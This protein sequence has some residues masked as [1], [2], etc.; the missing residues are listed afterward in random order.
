MAE[1]KQD[2][3]IGYL[4]G[5]F[6]GFNKRFGEF[7]NEIRGE[8][9]DLKKNINDFVNTHVSRIEFTQLQRDVETLKGNQKEFTK[10]QESVDKKM[11]KW[12]II[13]SIAQVAIS[14]VILPIALFI[15]TRLL[16][17]WIDSFFK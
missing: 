12:G 3:D 10:R 8:I 4:L 7:T 1:E 14:M 9:K 13:I 11:L 5:A 15:T 17:H 2:K 16:G 6:D